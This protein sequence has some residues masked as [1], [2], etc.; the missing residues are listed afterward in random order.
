MKKAVDFIS[1]AGFIFI[2]CLIG[3]WDSGQIT[4]TRAALG[5]LL[6]FPSVIA[7]GFICSLASSVCE[8]HQ[9]KSIKKASAKRKYAHQY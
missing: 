6:T 7:G 9:R 3:L 2:L 4:G 1:I 8:T 5:I